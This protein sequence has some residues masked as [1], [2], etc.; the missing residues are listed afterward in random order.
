[1]ESYNNP[2]IKQ[3]L[4]DVK[5]NYEQIEVQIAESAKKHKQEQ[6][7]RFQNAMGQVESLKKYLKSEVANRKE[8]EI[9]FDKAIETK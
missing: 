2:D 4:N 9:H 3:A 6:G 7:E 5:K 1:M 8:T